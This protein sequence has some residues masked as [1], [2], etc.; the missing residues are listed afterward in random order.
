ML[1]FFDQKTKITIFLG[2]L[3]IGAVVAGVFVWE[4]ANSKQFSNFVSYVGETSHTGLINTLVQVAYEESLQKKY[5]ESQ[6]ATKKVAIG[7]KPNQLFDINLEVDQSKVAQLSELTARVVFTSFGTV[8]T[9]VEMTFDILDSS[10]SVVNTSKGF[11]TVETEAVYNKD[12]FGFSLPKGNYTLRVITLYNTDVKDYF[13][14]SFSV[15]AKSGSFK[16]NYFVAA[17]IFLFFMFTLSVNIVKYIKQ[18]KRYQ[19]QYDKI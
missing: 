12:F 7:N 10:G 13:Y 16:T 11:T 14:Q 8:P 17:L 4:K 1:N 5:A 6:N 3:F 9:P 19:K 15:A 2:V 18:Y